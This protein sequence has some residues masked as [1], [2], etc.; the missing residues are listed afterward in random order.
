VVLIGDRNE[1][2][3]YR[4]LIEQ[5]GACDLVSPRTL[6]VPPMV[7]NGEGRVSTVTRNGRRGPRM[8]TRGSMFGCRQY[9]CY[10]EDGES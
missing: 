2:S 7:V 5:E 9:D 8:S 10:P 4:A 1:A 6:V 3:P